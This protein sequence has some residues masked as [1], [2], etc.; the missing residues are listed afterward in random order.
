MDK[1]EIGSTVMWNK[2]WTMHKF[3]HLGTR[4]P[5]K[6]HNM[7]KGPCG[8]LVQFTENPEHRAH[9]DFLCYAKIKKP[10]YKML[11]EYCIFGPR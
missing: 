7:Y 6:V 9:I 5:F 10:F 4:G 2:D 8:M 1:I 11:Y 3:E